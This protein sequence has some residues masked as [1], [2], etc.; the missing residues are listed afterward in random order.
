M[1]RLRD[2]LHRKIILQTRVDGC[3]QFSLA[4]GVIVR[5]S[6]TGKLLEV[7]PPLADELEYDQEP[8]LSAIRRLQVRA[9][10]LP[11]PFTLAPASVFHLG[12]MVQR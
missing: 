12:G 9:G 3:W 5:R 2:C 6:A 11:P 4:E 8:E 10:D 1:R 7:W